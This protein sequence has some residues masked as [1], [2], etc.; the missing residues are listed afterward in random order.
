M[1][2]AQQCNALSQ[3]LLQSLNA[4]AKRP[5]MKGSNI[6]DPYFRIRLLTNNTAQSGV[7]AGMDI[8]AILAAANSNHNAD[9]ATDQDA[10]QH[11]HVPPPPQQAAW[12]MLP[13]ARRSSLH[14]TRNP[15]ATCR[16]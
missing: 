16:A 8:K 1:L 11:P 12:A 6:W 5:Q 14:H 9:H 3:P 15:T 10:L 2:Q 4:L 7:Q 13:A